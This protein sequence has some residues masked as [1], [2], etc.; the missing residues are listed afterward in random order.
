MKVLIADDHALF[1]D[2]LG[3]LVESLDDTITI[4]Q[5]SNFAQTLKILN[6]ENDFDLIITD[7]EMSDVS[8]WEQGF[9][10][11]KK[12]APTS[13]IVIISASENIRNIRKTE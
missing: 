10:K 1:R 6:Q 13:Q 11:I 4:V 2:A 8:S 12:A 7:L 3:K 5:T 9:E